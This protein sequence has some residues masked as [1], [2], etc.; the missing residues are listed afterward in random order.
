MLREEREKR[1]RRGKGG[2]SRAGAAEFAAAVALPCRRKV[3]TARKRTTK[4]E[5][6]RISS[7]QSQR[8]RHPHRGSTPLRLATAATTKLAVVAIEVEERECV[9]EERESAC[10]RRRRTTKRE[11]EA[12]DDEPRGEGGGLFSHRP[13][14]SS[15]LPSIGVKA[16][17]ISL[18]VV[19]VFPAVTVAIALYAVCSC[20]HP[21]RSSHLL[22]EYYGNGETKK[23]SWRESQ[24]KGLRRFL[25]EKEEDILKALMLDLGKHQVEAFRGE[26]GTLMKSLNFALS[27]LKYWISGK[28]AKLSQ[29]ALLSSAEIVSEPLGLVLIISS[30]NFPFGLSLEPL[31]GAV[32]TG[33]T[34]SCHQHVLENEESK[35]HL[36]ITAELLIALEDA[37]CKRVMITPEEVIKRSL[38]PLGATVSRDGLAKTLYSCLFDWLVQ[39]INVSIGQ[40]P[41]SKCLIGVLDIYGFESF[42]NNSFVLISQMKSCSNISTRYEHVFKMEQERYTK[43]G[44]D[45]S[46]LEFVDNQDVLDL[47]EKKPGGIIALLDE[48]CYEKVDQY[49]ATNAKST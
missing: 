18:R 46:Y 42:K 16:I 17:V 47:I 27:N 28:K 48:A 13:A 32:A 6:D 33:N 12:E 45:W 34:V 9:R 25:I 4:R 2:R 10:S 15:R 30:W 20:H 44:I 38:D 41:E 26:I 43:E 24:L 1:R 29:I 14:L 11:G 7:P 19:M 5:G 23:V 3:R 22:T 39:K 8:R 40:D 31:I 37:L 21:L 36:Q 35:L 49:A